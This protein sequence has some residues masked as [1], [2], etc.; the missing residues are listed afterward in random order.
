MGAEALPHGFQAVFNE[1]LNANPTWRAEPRSAPAP[2]QRAPVPLSAQ[3]GAADW[4]EQFLATARQMVGPRATV[5]LLRSVSRV[6]DGPALFLI[7]DGRFSCVLQ[8]SPKAFPNAV[9]E[10]AERARAF[11]GRLPLA[12]ADPV[13]QPLEEGRYDGRSF[14]I[15]PYHRPFS[16]NRYLWVMQRS[17]VAPDLFDWILGLSRESKLPRDKGPRLE[18]YRDNLA[19]IATLMTGHDALL[20]AVASGTDR[21]E[22]GEIDPRFAPMHGDLWRGN[23]LRGSASGSHRFSVIDWRGS[24]I[25]GFPMFDLVRLSQSFRQSSCQL[26]REL[27]RHA[28]ALDCSIRDLEVHLLAALGH[29][30]VHRGEMLLPNFAAMAATAHRSFRNALDEA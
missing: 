1:G 23:I 9:A 14:T 4:D 22:R 16:N 30:A 11:A 18:T 20:R 21:I 3:S 19:C 5:R 15:L 24:E 25:D 27:R 12:L 7:T 17:G 29:Y 8:L 2:L 10:G 13:L 6:A 26:A 28:G